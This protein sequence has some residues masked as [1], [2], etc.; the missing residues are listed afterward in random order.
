MAGGRPTSYRSEYAEQAS[1]L[2]ELGATDREI[3]HFFKVKERT[4]HRW[5][6]Q[7]PEFCHALKGGKEVA[8]ERVERSLYRKAIGYSFDA[9]KILQNS[10]APVIVPY[11]EHVPPDTTAAIFWLKNRRPDRWRDMKAV[12]H[13]GP[14]GGPI[15]TVNRIERK[16]VRANPQPADS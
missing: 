12:E 5:K 2:C 13:A 3:A 4:V 6:L 1:R 11:V 7:F 14:D 15:Q 10:G 9:V 8:D 16:I